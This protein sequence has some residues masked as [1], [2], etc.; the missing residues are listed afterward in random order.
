MH[1]VTS[2]LDFGET[3]DSGIMD[4]GS[5]FQLDTANLALGA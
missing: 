3:F 1:T 2:S 5:T 4:P